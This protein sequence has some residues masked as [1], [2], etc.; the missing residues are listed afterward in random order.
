[1]PKVLNRRTDTIPPNAIYVGRPSKWG[2]PYLVTDPLLP[3]GLSKRSLYR[4]YGVSGCYWCPF[5]QPDIYRRVLRDQP[6]I[7]DP[8]IECEGKYG[9]SVSGYIYLRD[10]KAEILKEG[11]GK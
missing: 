6:N 4:R 1:M 9:A 2:N 5:Y 7:Y 8:F 10:L 3:A 11:V